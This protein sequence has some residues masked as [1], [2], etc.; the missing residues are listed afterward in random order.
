MPEKSQKMQIFALKYQTVKKSVNYLGRIG[1]GKK[2]D[3]GSFDTQY[4]IIDMM[5][6]E[7][8]SKGGLETMV[9]AMIIW[10]KSGSSLT[11]SI[12]CYKIDYLSQYSA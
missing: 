5:G 10:Y 1:N 2:F 3:Q 8:V 9:G 6:K 7:Q 12:T 11:S 4:K